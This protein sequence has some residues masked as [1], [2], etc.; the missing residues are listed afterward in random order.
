MSVQARPDRHRTCDTEFSQVTKGASGRLC[1]YSLC[2]QP[3]FT[4]RV[5]AP[6]LLGGFASSFDK[7]EMQNLNNTDLLSDLGEDFQHPFQ[8]VI[9]VDGHVTGPQQLFSFG[10]GW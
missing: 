9:G 4:E 7:P 8:L 6:S 3:Q 5:R 10:Y 2:Q 1:L